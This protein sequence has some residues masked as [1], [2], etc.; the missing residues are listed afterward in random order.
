MNNSENIYLVGASIEEERPVIDFTHPDCKKVDWLLIDEVLRG[1]HP[2][3]ECQA[4]SIPVLVPG[5]NAWSFYSV[6]G[7]LGL[8]SRK[9][10]Q[11]IGDS[12]FQH[13]QLL[14]ARLNDEEYCFLRAEKKLP[15]LDIGRS[16]IVA[17]RSNPARIKQ[18][19]KYAFK[20]DAIDSYVFFSI[21]EFP[22]LFATEAILQTVKQ[23]GL[24]G[25][26]FRQ[27][28]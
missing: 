24:A 4:V 19:K 12:A 9:A 5:A 21:P 10:V 23:N 22:G 7:T 16:D 2:V 26:D 3:G 28:D 6:A 18:I 14:S 15:V 8:I 13:F 11:I 20:K 1:M 17:F 25:F 27:V